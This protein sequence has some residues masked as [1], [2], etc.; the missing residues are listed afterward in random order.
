MNMP[1]PQLP[2]LLVLIHRLTVALQD[3][4]SLLQQREGMN[5]T[6]LSDLQQK[7]DI[8]KIEKLKHEADELR[9]HLRKSKELEKRKKE[10][11]RMREKTRKWFG[12]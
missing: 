6:H 9:A 8:E 4:E 3:V 11:E 12:I 7:R 1:T 10:Q 5:E 2:T